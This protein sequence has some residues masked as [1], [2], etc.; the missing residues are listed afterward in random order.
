MHRRYVNVVNLAPIPVLKVCAPDVN[1][2][3]PI[4]NGHGHAKKASPIVIKKIIPTLERQR[5]VHE[6]DH[7]VV[8]V[9]VFVV[10]DVI[11]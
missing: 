4:F 3:D 6:M 7:D 8:R 10:V 11:R 5:I 9:K 1:H 2:M